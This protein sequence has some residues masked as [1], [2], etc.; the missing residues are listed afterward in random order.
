MKKMNFYNLDNIKTILNDLK[1]NIS[2][3]IHNNI[4]ATLLPIQTVGVQGDGRTYS[5]IAAL[6][7]T[8]HWNDLFTLS[9]IIPKVNI[10]EYL[11]IIIMQ[12]CHNINRVIY[13]FGEATKKKI[14]NVTPT[15]LT[16][17]TIN[18][19]QIADDI[20]NNILMREQLINKLSQVPVILFPI[21]FD[22]E[23]LNSNKRSIAIR[24]F[25]TNDFM[26]GTPAIPGI[27]LIKRIINFY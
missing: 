13:I 11:S 26:T 12:I 21:D 1:T 27:N 15:Y 8:K 7:G 4:Y 24:T 14:L 10:S 9:K 16:E 17:E 23:S 18:Q 3:P 22:S 25:I 6:S 19:L 2:N 5:Y 20:V